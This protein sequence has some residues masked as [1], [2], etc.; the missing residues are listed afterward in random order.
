MVFG[1]NSFNT[2][3]NEQGTGDGMIVDPNA[4]PGCMDTSAN[5]YNPDATED[6]G[7]CTYSGCMDETANNYNE[8]ATEDDDSC[9]YDVVGCMD[10]TACNYDETATVDS[11][12]CKYGDECGIFS[13]LENW[14]LVAGAIVLVVLLK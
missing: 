4:V 12:D 14:H 7:S 3:F 8:E 9:T 10:E 2:V 13:T 6:D 1:H 11:E 5:N